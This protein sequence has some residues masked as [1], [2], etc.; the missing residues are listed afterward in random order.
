MKKIIIG[1]LLFSAI[2]STAQQNK[3]DSIQPG[4]PILNEM[5]KAE[6]E[7]ILKQDQQGRAMIDSVQ[8]KF[9]IESKEL[10]QLMESISL[11]DSINL[12]R[13]AAIITQYGWPGKS[14]VGDKA[15]RTVFLVIQHAE[16]ESQKKYLPLLSESVAKGESSAGHLAYLE[17]RILMREGKAQIYGTQIVTDE[18]TGKW[19][20]YPIEDEEHVDERRIKIGLK[21][22][23][24]YV[25]QF[26]IEY[27]K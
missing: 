17:D 23:A 18:A 9:G 19:K 3:V 15:N 16:L 6:L 13:I 12:Q 14:L 10:I 8:Q 27:K 11:N 20:I 24:E 1:L 25:K 4:K 2:E 21:P 7:I 22:L 5:L 26:G